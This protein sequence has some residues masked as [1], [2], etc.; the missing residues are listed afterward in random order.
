MMYAQMTDVQR[1]FCDP[2]G[3]R[4]S[5]C[6]MRSYVFEAPDAG[7]SAHAQLCMTRLLWAVVCREEVELG[8]CKVRLWG[9]DYS[10]NAMH[11]WL[12]GESPC[13]S[14]HMLDLWNSLGGMRGDGWLMVPEPC[15][16]VNSHIGLDSFLADVK[17]VFHVRS[18]V[19]PSGFGAVPELVECSQQRLKLRAPLPG[20]R[21][22]DCPFP[23]LDKQCLACFL[24]LACARPWRRKPTIHMYQVAGPA[25]AVERM[26]SDF[27]RD[28]RPP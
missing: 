26:N 13:L 18:G 12:E 2:I 22:R 7:R 17:T 20:S 6:R 21:K 16:M 28:C 1:C 11:F 24:C 14:R 19:A 4:A 23:R 8:T 9:F 3:V 10:E 25:I 15:A 5:G 27:S